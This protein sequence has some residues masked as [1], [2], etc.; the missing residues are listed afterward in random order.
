MGKGPQVS[1]WI[2]SQTFDALLAL[3]GNGACGDFPIRHGMQRVG[4]EGV[5]GIYVIPVAKLCVSMS[6]VAS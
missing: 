1:I 3:C 2:K 4:V 6:L 5:V